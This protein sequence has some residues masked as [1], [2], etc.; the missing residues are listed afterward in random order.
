MKN[1]TREEL[2]ERMSGIKVPKVCI[3]G[4]GHRGSELEMHFE[5]VRVKVDF[6]CDNDVSKHGTLVK[7]IPCLSLTELEKE[8]EDTLVIVSPE[9]GEEIITQLKEAGFPHVRSMEE[10]Y[11]YATFVRNVELNI[12]NHCNLDCRFCFHFSCVAP[13]YV[14]PLETLEKD[15]RCFSDVMRDSLGTLKVIGGEPLLHPNLEEILV[16]GRTH[17]PNATIWLVS[18]GVLLQKKP[19]N[20]WLTC[21]E[22][23]I[24]IVVTKYPINLDF[25]KMEELAQS[26]GVRFQFT[27]GIGTVKTMNKLPLN[28]KGTCDPKV[29]FDH[30]HM[31]KN[32]PMLLHGKLYL[33][34]VAAKVYTFNEVFEQNIEITKEDYIDIYSNPTLEDITAFR[35]KPAPFCKY[36]NITEVVTELPWERTKGAMED[37]TM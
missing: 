21:K 36:C 29:S 27:N 6:F 16:L 7:G 30:C 4:A 34:P 37:W 22:N 19:E 17:F 31:G 24:V 15:L 33:C 20:F 1:Y 35:S 3:F 28:L 18:N 8:K 26:H 9:K 11:V 5:I 32:C 13:E 10:V 14:V 2:I 12:V 23:D 25:E